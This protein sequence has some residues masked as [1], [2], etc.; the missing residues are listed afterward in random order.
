MGKE[1]LVVE[2]QPSIRLLLTEILEW[3]GYVVTVAIDGK[4]ALNK[5]YE[6]LF[7]LIMLNYHLPILSGSEVIKQLR[8]DE[9]IVP[10]ILM[11]GLIEGIS[12]SQES[13]IVD[14]VAKPFNIQD[15]SAIVKSHLAS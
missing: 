10:T 13:P 11:T 1:I 7:D 2:D 4:E 3:E 9:I 14:V 15:I 8:I 12:G 6:N 5:I